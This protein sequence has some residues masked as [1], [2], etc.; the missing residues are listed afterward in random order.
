MSFK[1][2]HDL[3]DLKNDYYSFSPV[4]THQLFSDEEIYG[5]K[6]L[7]IIFYFTCGSLFT[8]W[9]YDF[10]EKLPDA[11]NIELI[12]NTKLL[13]GFTNDLNEFSLYLY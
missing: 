8:Y 11:D 2:I 10:E 9:N 13:A 5:Y 6:K 12:I 4:F 7:S 3:N 1:L